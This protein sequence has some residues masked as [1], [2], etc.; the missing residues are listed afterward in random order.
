VVGVGGAR[1]RLDQH[2]RRCAHKL[3]VI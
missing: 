3:L 2:A 1:V